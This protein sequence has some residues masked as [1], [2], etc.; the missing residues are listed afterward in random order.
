MTPRG[1]GFDSLSAPSRGILTVDESDK[2]SNE[3]IDVRA[4]LRSFITANKRATPHATKSLE[5]C[6][7]ALDELFAALTA[8]RTDGSDQ[9][10]VRLAIA[11]GR[12]SG[13]NVE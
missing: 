3:P 4:A 9:N 8:Y 7:P 2:V 13:I 5:R 12:A 11:H 10:R 1:R 6:M